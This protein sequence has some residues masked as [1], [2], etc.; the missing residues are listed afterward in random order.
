[1]KRRHQNWRVESKVLASSGRCQ[2]AM[3]RIADDDFSASRSVTVFPSHHFLSYREVKALPMILVDFQYFV[4]DFLFRS[5]DVVDTCE[6]E[7][8]EGKLISRN[9]WN[10]YL[11]AFLLFLNFISLVWYF[12]FHFEIPKG[13]SFTKCPP[14][15]VVGKLRENKF[16][17]KEEMKN[18]RKRKDAIIKIQI[19]KKK[20]LTICSLF[21]SV[22]PLMPSVSASSSN[23]VIWSSKTFTSPEYMNVISAASEAKLVFDGKTIT[24]CML[25]SSVWKSSPKNVLQPLSTSR[26]AR[27]FLPSATIVQ[28]ERCDWSSNAGNVLSKDV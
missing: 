7:W 27:I 6:S 11:R 10:D 2:M 28:S 23:F 5:D 12:F 24:G 3:E 4:F 8:E 19:I 15:G 1:M 26:C 18:S 16:P 21:I 22:K 25:D 9:K 14:T 17:A 20:I 13:E